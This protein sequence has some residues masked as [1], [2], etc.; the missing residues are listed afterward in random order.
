MVNQ[1]ANFFNFVKQLFIARWRGLLLLLLGVYLPLQ[2]FGFLAIE[3]WKNAGGFPWDEPIL[4]T[5][6]QT[7]TP[8]LDQFAVILT[9]FGSLKVVAPLVMGISLAFSWQ[10]KWRSLAFLVTTTLGT[11]IINF[12]AKTIMHRVRPHLWQSLSPEFG[13]AFPSGHAMT[14]MTL[15]GALVILTWGTIWSWLIL[16][17]G[18]IF[19]VAIG[20]TRLYLGVHF[21]S[22]ILAGWMVS[23]AWAIGVTLLIKPQLIKAKPI[24][25]EDLKHEAS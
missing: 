21:P 22:D 10:K 18:S 5:I 20:W 11:A 16:I 4:L 1:I 2:C 3:V 24:S 19:V 17:F 7:A 13:Y 9:H 14:S 8:Q 15:I 6:H 25:N 23:L 12:T